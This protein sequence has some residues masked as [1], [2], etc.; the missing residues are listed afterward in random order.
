MTGR[1]EKRTVFCHLETIGSCITTDITADV[2]S[3]STREVGIWRRPTHGT[4]PSIRG[5]D[6][7]RGGGVNS[8]SYRGSR[9]WSPRGLSPCPAGSRRDFSANWATGSHG[10]FPA[11][12]PKNSIRKT[13]SGGNNW[14]DI[15]KAKIIRKCLIA[16]LISMNEHKGII[17]FLF[18][19]SPENWR[20]V[21]F[22][23]VNTAGLITHTWLWHE[24]PWSPIL[25]IETSG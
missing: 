24:R 25:T 6:R 16:K 8:G 13:S 15:K 9:S 2:L 23:S 20:F 10:Y 1:Y 3:N 14:W 12:R 7:R 22:G 5:G 4:N 11:E 21:L 19:L 18:F 17:G